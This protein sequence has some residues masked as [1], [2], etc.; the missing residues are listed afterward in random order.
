MV[1]GKRFSGCPLNKDPTE[2]GGPAMHEVVEEFA[3]DNQKFVNE[4]VAVFQKMIAN[5]YQDVNPKNNQPLKKSDWEWVN[6]RC[7]M[8]KCWVPYS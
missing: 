2:E 1:P 3:S 6:M 4:F 8:E 5:G 7:T